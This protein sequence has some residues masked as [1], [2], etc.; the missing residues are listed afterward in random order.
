MSKSYTHLS[1]EEF[2]LDV[3]DK[4]YQ[5]PILKEFGRRLQHSIDTSVVAAD[6]NH[7]ATCPVCEAEL[8]VDYDEGNSLFEVKVNRDA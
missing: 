4:V 2:L 3:G 1:D 5:S 8:V 6:A 7:R